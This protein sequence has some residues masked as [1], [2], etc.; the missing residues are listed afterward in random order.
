MITR[1]RIDRKTR[2]D[3]TV[4]VNS[5]KMKLKVCNFVRGAVKLIYTSITTTISIKHS[6]E[7]TNL[8]PGQTILR[9]HVALAFFQ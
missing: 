7:P 9:Y 5:K 3:S 6:T 4:N 2:T 8:P 1:P